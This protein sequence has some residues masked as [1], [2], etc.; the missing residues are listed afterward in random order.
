MNQ[1]QPH[2]GR[3]FSSLKS[4]RVYHSASA[5]SST[6]FSNGDA[7]DEEAEFQ[8][9]RRLST[10]PRLVLL[11]LTLLQLPLL[12]LVLLR[13]VLLPLVPLALPGPPEPLGLP[14]PLGAQERHQPRHSHP[15]ELGCKG[16]HQDLVGDVQ[17]AQEGLR[18][19]VGHRCP[20]DSLAAPF[21]R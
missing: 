21:C 10:Q 2:P 3:I 15:T 20:R 19:L 13:L 18:T 11:R 1:N 5:T 14:E 12:R 17:V 16:C 4:P 8:L 9:L 6:S 7:E